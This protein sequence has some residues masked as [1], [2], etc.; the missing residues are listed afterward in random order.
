MT[1]APSLLLIL[2]LVVPL[3][4]APVAWRLPVR[5][6]ER[7]Q[8]IGSSLLLAVA[9]LLAWR[10]FTSGPL[11]LDGL[12]YADALSP[13]LLAVVAPLPRPPPPTGSPLSPPTWPRDP[14]PPP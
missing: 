6:S 13:L 5:W 4:T 2:P 8:V 10:I 1:I 11:A 9:W 14:S 3:V 7:A 12:L